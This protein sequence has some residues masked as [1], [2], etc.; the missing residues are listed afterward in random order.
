MIKK[1]NK[2]KIFVICIAFSAIAS[3]IAT[4]IILGG[5]DFFGKPSETVIEQN[6]PYEEVLSPTALKI[7]SM[8][9]QLDESMYRG[10]VE[11]LCSFGP[12]PTARRLGYKLFDLP[13]E[14]VANY[15]YD[16]FKS[17]GLEVSYKHWEEEPTKEN[18]MK[19]SYHPGWQIGDNIEAILPGTDKNSDEI[20]VLLAHYDTMN[21]LGY[22]QS[23]PFEKVISIV[24][25]PVCKTLRILGAND[26]SSGVAAL[27]AIAK[28]MNQYKFNHTVRFVAVTGEEQGLQGS[29]WYAKEAKENNDNIV[30]A[31]VIDMIGTTPPYSKNNEIIFAG[32]LDNKPNSVVDLTVDVNQRYSDFFKFKIFR[33]DP[34]SDE[35][36]S[37]QK[38]F[39]KYD[40]DAIYVAEP[41]EDL[42][43]HRFT[44]TIENMDIPYATEVTRLLLATI[45]ELAGLILKE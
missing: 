45:T 15:I 37:D 2:N 36:G 4:Y 40:Y 5:L 3:S 44:D 33:G 17:M 9:S 42:D 6:K 34:M 41:V 38:S 31:F 13:I 25:G 20:Y 18:L 39:I 32:D 26:D 14:K 10:Y 11:K 27:L 23:R 22:N 7:K 43:W 24:F 19:P 35:F 28:I 1:S 30:V 29:D 21:S 12:H 16:E 8:L